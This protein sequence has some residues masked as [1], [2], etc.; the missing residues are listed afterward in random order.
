M[1]KWKYT[2]HKE[3]HLL[4]LNDPQEPGDNLPDIKIRPPRAEDGPSRPKEGI[5]KTARLSPILKS[6]ST[7]AYI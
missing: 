5:T 3:D 2:A 4:S 1:L 7:K 6:P